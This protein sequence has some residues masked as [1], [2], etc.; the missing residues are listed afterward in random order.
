MTADDD[1]ETQ[2]ATQLARMAEIIDDPHLSR[3]EKERLLDEITGEGATT[4]AVMLGETTGCE[5]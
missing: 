2:L 4:L 3:S 1:L 5:D